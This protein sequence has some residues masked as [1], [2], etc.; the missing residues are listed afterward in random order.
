MDRNTP[1]I[2]LDLTLISLALIGFFPI[3]VLPQLTL[4]GFQVAIADGHGMEPSVQDGD[5][6]LQRQTDPATLEIGDVITFYDPAKSQSIGHRI[7]AIRQ[8]NNQLW[9]TTK[10]DANRAPDEQEVTFRD[11]PAWRHAGTIPFGV[12]ALVGGGL[13]LI[14]LSLIVLAARLGGRVVVGQAPAPLVAFEV[15]TITVMFGA[16]AII[17]TFDL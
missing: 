6:I 15:V 1:S 12:E 8:F 14:C 2:W 9:F 7:V 5:L 13:L 16:V 10:G 11:G 17:G 3:V 4:F